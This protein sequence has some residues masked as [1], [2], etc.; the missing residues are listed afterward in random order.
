MPVASSRSN[1]AHHRNPSGVIVQV[2][3]MVQSLAAGVLESPC[4][5]ADLVGGLD[6]L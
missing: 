3:A 1:C 2:L 5:V 6:F 4:L